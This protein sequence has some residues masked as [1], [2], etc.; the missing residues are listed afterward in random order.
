VKELVLY[1]IAFLLF[2]GAALM[3][4]G[5]IVAQGF[6]A[7]QAGGVLMG[8]LGMLSHYRRRRRLFKGTLLVRPWPIRLGG[9]V[10][11]K[12]RAMLK[13]SAPISSLVAKLRCAE[14][15]TIGSGRYQEKKSAPLFELELQCSNHER[16][17]V[18]EEWTVAIPPTHPPSFE[19]PG[20]SVRWG[21]TTMLTTSGVEIPAEFT[22]VV[23]PEVAE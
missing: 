8:F 13:K 4:K 23:I 3:P 12:Y 10:T 11:L 22:L 20:N 5:G 18:E 19:V 6:R 21:L 14:D 16:R 15:V 1:A 2:L 9:E 17:V 7:L